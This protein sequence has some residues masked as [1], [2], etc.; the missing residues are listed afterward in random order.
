[1]STGPLVFS[2][3]NVGAFYRV[4]QDL[5]GE[6]NAVPVLTSSSVSRTVLLTDRE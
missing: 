5:D 6:N 2:A 3:Q 1:M 4:V